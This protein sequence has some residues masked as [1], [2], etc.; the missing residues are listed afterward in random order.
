[1]DTQDLVPAEILDITLSDMGFIVFLKPLTKKENKVAVPIFI[2][3][4]E[5]QSIAIQ[6]N[7]IRSPRPL[8]MDLFYNI[9]NL[10]NVEVVQVIISDFIDKTFYAKIYLKDKDGN[11]FKVDARSSD[12]IIM[13]LRFDAKIYIRKYIIEEEG[14]L[15][16]KENMDGQKEQGKSSKKVKTRLQMIEEELKKALEEERYEDA[17]KLRD[18]IKKIK[19]ET[20]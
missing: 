19:G 10:M 12:A 8:I 20:N 4:P 15:I 14:I 1:M 13:A 9:M 11:Q 6:F 17:V 3:I 18:E 16:K 7:K 2:G 5:A